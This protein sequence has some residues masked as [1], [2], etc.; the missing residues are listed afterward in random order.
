MICT[1]KFNMK[2]LLDTHVF[3][4]M[5][6]DPQQLSTKVTEIL[7]GPQYI[8]LMSI[9]SVWEMQIKIRKGKLTLSVPLEQIVESEIEVNDLKVLPVE[10]SHIWAL[11][12]LENYHQDPFDRLLIA[13]SIAENIPLLSRDEVFD[14]YPVRRLW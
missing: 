2:F 13:Q 10:L 6:Q 11:G 1:P 4:W 14:L 9:V 5:D 3:I 8:I 7:A 12:K